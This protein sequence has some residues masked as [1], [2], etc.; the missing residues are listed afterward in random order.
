MTIDAASG[1]AE[2]NGGG[3]VTR[4]ILA[5]LA[6]DSL[7]FHVLNIYRWHIEVNRFAD[8]L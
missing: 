4:V 2:R 5:G 1:V 6:A 3:E 7:V 8:Q